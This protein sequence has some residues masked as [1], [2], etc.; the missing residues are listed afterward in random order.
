MSW[1]WEQ[2][3]KLGSWLLN[4]SL[5]WALVLGAVCFL[6]SFWNF[7][8]DSPKHFSSLAS[9]IISGGFFAVMLKSIQ[10]LGLFRE[11]MTNIFKS[12]PFLAIFRGEITTTLKS[13]QFLKVFRDEMPKIMYAP[14]S[15]KKR[16]D[17][18]EI[19]RN[20]SKALYQSKFPQISEAIEN[21]ILD[22]YLPI[23]E[24]FYYD[25]LMQSV[26]Y[27]IHDSHE[28]FVVVTEDLR[29]VV[30]PI[31]SSDEV[32]LP[33]ETEIVKDP[34]DTDVTSYELLGVWINDVDKTSEISPDVSK[35]QAG[36]KKLVV[37]FSLPKLQGEKMYQVRIKHRKVCS[38]D[39]DDTKSFTSRRFINTLDLSVIYP[40]HKLDVE[41][42]STGTPTDFKSLAGDDLGHIRKKLEGLIFPNQGYRLLLRRKQ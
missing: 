34:A 9:I 13:D 36:G 22:T 17:I 14:E 18:E 21:L 32:E 1:I 37:T 25:Q 15:L 16:N 20:V 40:K 28:Q 8:P 10:F 5:I 26:A 29:Y 23:K 6:L 33:Y 7:W 35:D 24:N 27:E 12:E 3:K 31:N 11:E 42:F 38:L 41:F 4:Y 19:W 39:F 30:I 2:L